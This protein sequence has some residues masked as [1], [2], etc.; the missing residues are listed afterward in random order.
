MKGFSFLKDSSLE[1]VEN[2][3]ASISL[4]GQG[5]GVEVMKQ[6]TSSGKQIVL[7]PGDN[8]EAAEFYYILS[9]EIEGSVDGKKIEFEQG[10]FFSAQGLSHSIQFYAKTDVTVLSVTTTPLFHYISKEI[11]EL[12]N[13]G[14][15]VEKKDR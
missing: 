8:P 10:D 2:G 15:Q 4:L 7:F 1:S 12:R 11:E 3:A 9:G 14:E 13:V 6:T 5:D